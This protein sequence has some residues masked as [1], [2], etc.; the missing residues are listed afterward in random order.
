MG[1]HPPEQDRGRA[2]HD[3]QEEAR[4]QDHPV[5][6]RSTMLVRDT[7]AS[8]MSAHAGKALGTKGPGAWIGRTPR[9]VHAEAYGSVD[10]LN[11]S[12]TG[13]PCRHYQF[14]AVRSASR[15]ADSLAAL[16]TLGA[17]GAL[18]NPDASPSDVGRQWRQMGR[19]HRTCR[20]RGV[21]VAYPEARLG[22]SRP[23]ASNY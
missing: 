4:R 13:F 23:I 5:G 8:E 15:D 20:T 7:S 14:R 2:F 11:T 21:A 6:S 22:R 3:Y 18:D 17:D 12:M 9:H 16:V 19:H 1:L 10:R